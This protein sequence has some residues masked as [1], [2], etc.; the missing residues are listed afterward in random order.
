[1]DTQHQKF[2]E[3]EARLEQV[4]MLNTDMHFLLDDTAGK[5]FHKESLD[6]QEIDRLKMLWRD[7]Q[8][9]DQDVVSYFSDYKS[10]K[11]LSPEEAILAADIFLVSQQIGPDLQKLRTMFFTGYM[12]QV[13]FQQEIENISLPAQSKILL[14]GVGAKIFNWE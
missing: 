4:P 2:R 5:V 13:E 8:N 10:Q 6:E 9:K 11:I 7:F 1:M 3:M 14:K 12:N